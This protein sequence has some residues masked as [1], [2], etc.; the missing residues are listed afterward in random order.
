MILHCRGNLTTI[1][2][3]WVA[4]LCGGVCCGNRV[5]DGL[6]NLWR[7]MHMSGVVS[8]LSCF[9][10]RLTCVSVAWQPQKLLQTQRQVSAYRAD[11]VVYSLFSL[12]LA[13]STNEGACRLVS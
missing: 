13:S 4:W 9:M 5:A 6:Q 7:K 3:A 12:W 11:G 8:V 10:I 2:V 1:S